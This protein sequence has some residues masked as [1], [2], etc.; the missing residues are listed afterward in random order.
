MFFVVTVVAILTHNNC[1]SPACFLFFVTP[2]DG[3]AYM[4]ACLLLRDHAQITTMLVV[5]GLGNP[6]VSVP[7]NG[8]VPS[9]K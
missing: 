1:R 2:C 9:P 5:F 7:H 6:S 3:T 8:W 4:L